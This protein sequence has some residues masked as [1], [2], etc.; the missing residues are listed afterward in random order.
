MYARYTDGHEAKFGVRWPDM[1]AADA[2]AL[3]RSTPWPAK[4]EAEPDAAFKGR[5]IFVDCRTAP[6]ILVSKIPGAL[7]ESEYRAKLVAADR[8]KHEGRRV[9]A[10]CTVGYRSGKFVVAERARRPT[11]DVVNMAGSLLAWTHAGGPLVDNEDRPTTR[12]HV[13]AKKWALAPKGI[14]MITFPLL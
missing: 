7:T 8:D 5:P 13:F 3:L 14:E 12:L 6:E 11:A 1:S 10:Y 4:D 2:V 9:V